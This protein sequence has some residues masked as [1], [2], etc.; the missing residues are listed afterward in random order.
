MSLGTFTNKGAL[1]TY[2]DLEDLTE[3]ENRYELSFGTLMVT[4]APN[5]RTFNW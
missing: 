1:F 2:P 4:P 5:T 3:D